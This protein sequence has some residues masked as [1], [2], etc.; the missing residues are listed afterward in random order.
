VVH[1]PADCRQEQPP[2]PHTVKIELMRTCNYRCTFCS[3]DYLAKREGRMDWS[4][5]EK[6]LLELRGLGVSEI[7]PFFFGESFL[8]FR[9]P[10]AIRLAR[11][12][13]F[14][15]IFLTTNGSAA[16]PMRVKECM[17]SGL[18]SLK[19]S[20]NAADAEQ[21]AAL[22]GADPR[23][24]QTVKD[25][26]KAA[27]QIRDEAG[28]KCGLYASYIKF[29]EQQDEKMKPVMAELA[30]YLDEI[31]ALP[32]YSQAAT[33]TKEGWSFTGGNT[34][35]L[36]NPV[37]VLPCWVLFREGHINFDG[38]VCA[39]SFSVSDD[40]IMGDLKHQTFLEIWQGEKFTA[41]RR[42]HLA[43]DVA[44]TVCGECVKKQ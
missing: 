31:Y 15:Y 5:Y 40:F 26:I 10:D 39:C 43:G 3:H 42:A 30:P 44:G 17:D 14:P 33:I 1:L 36:N 6:I 24:F 9:L 11:W 25:N 29:D 13:G 2:P 32:L 37:P 22:T 38:T 21:F 41:L 23:L 12:L 35:R 18:N 20:L 7:A 16:T 27:R 19:F 4:L 8:D 34:G 28:Y